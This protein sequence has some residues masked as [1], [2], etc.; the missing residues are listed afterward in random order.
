MSCRT[1]GPN[2]TLEYQMTWV[3]VGKV[4]VDMGMILLAPLLME[5]ELVSL[6]QF[7][8]ANSKFFRLVSVVLYNSGSF[9]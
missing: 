8:N 3:R 4:P 5:G 9:E 6:C 1:Q 2:L 7:F